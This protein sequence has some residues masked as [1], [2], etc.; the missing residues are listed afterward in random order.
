MRSASANYEA[1]HRGYL[2]ATHNPRVGTEAKRSAEKILHKLEAAHGDEAVEAAAQ[3]T[4][5]SHPP[6]AAVPHKEKAPYDH[7][8]DVHRHRVIGGLKATLRRD[9]RSDE[10]KAHA[11]DK[12]QAMG[13]T[14]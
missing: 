10:A 13:V 6:K 5:A 11:R 3:S 14:E 2:A 9:D 1:V 12:L 8:N 7:D 4:K